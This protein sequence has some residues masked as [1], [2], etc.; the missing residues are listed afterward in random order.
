MRLP[1]L[2]SVL[3]VKARRIPHNLGSLHALR[4]FDGRVSHVR[5]VVVDIDMKR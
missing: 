4:P 1:V 3:I 2:A 5:R